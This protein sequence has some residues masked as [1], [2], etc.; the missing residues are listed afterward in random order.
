MSEKAVLTPVARRERRAWY[1]Y[2]FGNSAYASVVLLAVYAAYFKD[3]VVGGAR[4]SFLWGLSVGLATLVVAIL[5]PILGALADA[6]GSKKRFLFAFTAVSCLFT[7]A[8]FFVT[9]GSIV[10][11]M[12]FFVLAEIGYRGAQ[13]FY[14]ALLPDIATEAEMGRV[15]GNGWAIGSAGGIVVLLLVIPLIQF[16]HASWAKPASL[17]LTAIFYAAFSIPIFLRLRERSVAHALPKGRE[18]LAL[19]F[20]RIGETFRAIRHYKEFGKFMLA[21]LVYND[22]ILMTLS[23]AAILGTVLFDLNQMQLLIFMILVQA[24]SVPGAYVLGRITDRTNA[25]TALLGSLVLMVGAIV[26]M[27]FNRSLVSFYVIGGVA[28]FALTGVQSVSRTMIGLLAPE[29]RSAE[30]YGF[31]SVAGRTS[32][33]IGPTVYGIVAARVAVALQNRGT[34]SL[35]A[36]QAGQR[37]AVLSILVFLVVGTLM[38]LLVNERAG[39]RARARNATGGTD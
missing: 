18:L 11:G 23:F 21:Y 15:S 19:P 29:G 39:R 28:G 13:V 10:A 3:I 26:W 24:T 17:V 6:G 8:L 30:F 34:E 22:G 14:D 37:A 31:F 38:L 16:V 36:E 4:G 32:S 5:S 35:L 20:R 9:E 1:L 33:F 7:A 2:D 27:Y 12:L 25:R